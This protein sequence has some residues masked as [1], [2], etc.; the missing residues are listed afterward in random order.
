MA[1]CIS[2]TGNLDSV[3]K[4]I[5]L[6]LSREVLI[7]RPVRKFTFF[8]VIPVLFLNFCL[9]IFS[10]KYDH[11]GSRLIT[12]EADKTIKMFKEDEEAVIEL[13]PLSS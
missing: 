2:G 5:S 4:N 8:A 13:I 9:G 11:S 7:P 10:V 12:T 1:L 3:F 6:S